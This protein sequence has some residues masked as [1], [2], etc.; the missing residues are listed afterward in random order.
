MQYFTDILS[1]L[2]P[3]GT[4]GFALHTYTHDDDPTLIVDEA[5]MRAPYE[6]RHF[7]FRAYQDFMAAV[8]HAMQHLPVY[9][10]EMGDSTTSSDWVQQAYAEI[11]QWNQIAGNQP[12]RA[13]A[14]LCMTPDGLCTIEDS[15]QLFDG[16][17]EVLDQ[18]YRWTKGSA[19]A[20][21][22]SHTDSDVDHKTIDMASTL[23][24]SPVNNVVNHPA[25]G[26]DSQSY[27]QYF[28]QATAPGEI[29]QA[30]AYDVQITPA[31]VRSGQAYWKVIGIYH[32]LGSENQG[33]HSIFVE[34][35][36]ENGERARDPGLRIGWTWE[37]KNDGPALQ[38]RLDKPNSEPASNI[39]LENG[40][41]VRLWVEGDEASDEVSGLHT[42]HPD[43][44]PGNSFGHHSFYVI[45]QR[46]RK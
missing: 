15:P 14:L 44:E 10:T 9:L 30:T 12:I 31:F 43:E 35:L 38:K 41:I 2:G 25:S 20:P 37:G 3:S 32:L 5:M 17:R 22:S 42:R 40:M 33:G 6:T 21:A 34:A 46:T 27:N 36:D 19:P 45:F 29:N 13:A 39:G 1:L 7:S 26:F 28:L 8:P 16:F 18:E 23:D 24:S 4:D 11:D